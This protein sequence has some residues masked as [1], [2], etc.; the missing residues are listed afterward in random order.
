MTGTGAAVVFP[1]AKYLL[2]LSGRQVF[3]YA[4]RP[5]ERRAHDALM[6]EG[7]LQQDRDALVGAAL[8]FAGDV[9]HHVLPA[10]VP[11]PRKVVGGAFRTLCQQEELHVRPP[12]HDLPGLVP[13]GIGLL[14]K[15]VA[16]HAD[17]EHLAAFDL[18][19]PAAV[20]GKRIAEARFRAVD[21]PAVFVPHGVEEVH[22]AVLAAFADLFAAVPRVPYIVQLRPPHFLSCITISW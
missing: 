14:Q 8:V 12:A 20:P 4:H 3:F 13:P 5:D 18:V 6:L 7:Q 2:D 9:E 15:E 16:G 22:I 11:V 10:A 17:P 1:V 21:I 19:L